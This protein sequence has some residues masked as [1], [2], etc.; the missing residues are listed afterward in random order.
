MSKTEDIEFAIRTELRRGPLTIE[1]ILDLP[2]LAPIRGEDPRWIGVAMMHLEQ[3]GDIA[4]RGCTDGH[5][6]DGPCVAEAA[7]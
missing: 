3:N 7:R 6:H 5:H 4:F 1:Q 2:I